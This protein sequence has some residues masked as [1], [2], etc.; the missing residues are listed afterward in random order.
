MHAQLQDALWWGHAVSP[1]VPDTC[2]VLLQPPCCDVLCCQGK[3]T[4]RNF[5]QVQR[6]I[7]LMSII[8][9]DAAAVVRTMLRVAMCQ[10]LRW[11][12]QHMAQ[13]RVAGAENTALPPEAVHGQQRMCRNKQHRRHD[14]PHTWPA[15]GGRTT[16]LVCNHFSALQL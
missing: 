8:R 3:M 13:S 14:Q 15:H 1:L 9:W 5:S 6:E 2:Y 7:R 16:H 4:E 12:A 10:G 11:P